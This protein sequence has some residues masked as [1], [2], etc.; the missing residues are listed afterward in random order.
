MRD[1]AR[2]DHDVD[3]CHY[4][5]TSGYI[6]G[7]WTHSIGHVGS[8]LDRQMEGQYGSPR[9]GQTPTHT[10]TRGT[11]EY[12]MLTGDP[13]GIEAARTISDHYGG[14]WLNNY[15][16]TNGRYPGW[17][18]IATMATYQAT[19]DPFYLNAGRIIVDRTME[20]RTPGGGW[21]RQLVP[22]HC[23]CEPRCRGLCSFMQGILGVGLR[24]YWLVTGDERIEEAIPEAARVVLD[25]IWVDDVEMFRYTSCPD[26]S[27]TASRADTMGGLMLFAWEL[28]G[29]QRFADVAIRSLNLGFESLGSLAHMRWTPYIVHALDRL[30]RLEEPGLGGERGATL[31]IRNEEAGSLQ[32]RVFDRDGRAAPAGAA[33]L[34]GPDGDSW[35]PA[36]DGRIVV[37]AGVEGVYRLKLERDTG[38]WQVT[39]S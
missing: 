21:M 14:A 4:H 28:S 36:A 22:G 19:G 11:T 27:L 29:D 12:F 7:S 37:E 30:H 5:D 33:K 17:H 23:H 10:W 8:Y 32:V 13:A 34:T 9:A 31:L 39:A 2:H 15:D 24:D 3:L 16:F 26:S 1:Q 6:G 35:R 20:R 38:P 18:L 25:E